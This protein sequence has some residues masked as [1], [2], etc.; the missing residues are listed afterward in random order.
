MRLSNLLTTAPTM[1]E[2]EGND[3]IV[4]DLKRL[5]WY[6]SVTFSG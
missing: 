3:T 4:E 1:V 2:G 6:F 5:F